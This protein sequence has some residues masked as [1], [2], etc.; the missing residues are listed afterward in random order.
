MAPKSSAHTTV[1]WGE[2][3]TLPR[4]TRCISQ[5]S[6][7]HTRYTVAKPSP[8][9]LFAA[10]TYETQ[11]ARL[12]AKARTRGR[13]STLESQGLHLA[14]LGT[15]TPGLCKAIAQT[16]EKGQFRFRPLRR[17][18]AFLGGKLRTLYRAELIDSLVLGAVAHRL[19]ALGEHLLSSNVFS[20]RPGRSPWQAIGR[21]L[22]FLEN[23]RKSRAN[24]R[25]HGIW[26]VQR[27]VEAF[28]DSIPT[29]EDS[30]LWPLLAELLSGVENADERRILSVLVPQAC[31][32]EY[33]NQAGQLELLQQGLPTGSPIQ[34]PLENLYLT[35]LDCS[36]GLMPDSLYTRFGDDLLHLSSSREQAA[37]A[38]AAMSR[39]TDQLRLTLKP[40][41]QNDFYFTKPGRH[42]PPSDGTWQPKPTSHIE[43]LGARISFDGSLGLKRQRCRE[44]MQRWRQRINNLV[45]IAGETADERVRG[46]ALGL[47]QSLS[48][49]LMVSDKASEALRDWVDDREQLKQLDYWLR[50]ECAQALSN[51]RGVRAFRSVPPQALREAGLPSLEYRRRRRGGKR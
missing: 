34:P 1:R 20:F 10:A 32:P 35:T 22:A 27:D 30:P 40:S 39:I 46:V 19:T 25:E 4:W 33:Q 21:V 8:P 38:A 16:V 11:L 17:T 5:S 6:A 31:R 50:L 44:L 45:A 41:K 7:P 14:A 29:T 37:V 15:D 18:Q 13:A 28:G 24:V 42:P 26:V 49:H 43:Y 48:P 3:S 36:L 23:H 12:G 47:E 2:Q 51:K 9:A